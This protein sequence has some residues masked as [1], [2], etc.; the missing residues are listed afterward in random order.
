MYLQLQETLHEQMPIIPLIVPQ[1]RLVIHKR[2]DTP[3]TPI[4]PGYSPQ[5]LKLEEGLVQ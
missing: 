5:L 2:Y 1:G 3:V 4:F